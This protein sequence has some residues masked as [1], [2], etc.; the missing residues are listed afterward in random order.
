MAAV[1]M[2]IA[3]EKAK[4][5][6]SMTNFTAITASFFL[7]TSHDKQA[8]CRFKFILC[9][10]GAS[11]SIHP[12]LGSAPVGCYCEP[13]TAQSEMASL[14]QGEKGKRIAAFFH[15]TPARNSVFDCV[16]NV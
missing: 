2:D 10:G 7:D 4:C 14:T 16:D 11:H 6:P 15:M 12:P 1:T 8:H 9:R 13:C 3:M 5:T